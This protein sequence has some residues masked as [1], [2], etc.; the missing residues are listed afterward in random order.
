ML[1]LEQLNE[2]SMQ[3]ILNAGDARAII[4]EVIVC[5]E[6]GNFEEAEE[7]MS[8]AKKKISFAH[9]SQTKAIQGEAMGDKLPYSVLFAHA[10]DTLMVVMS[11]L[12]T[13]RRLMKLFKKYDKR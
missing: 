1:D 8:E 11:E 9:S 12:N 5:I 10:Q 7:K 13:T 4:E 2:I 3:I 6:E